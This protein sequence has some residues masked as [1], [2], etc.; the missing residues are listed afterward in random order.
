M[1]ED[2]AHRREVWARILNEPDYHII[3]AEEDGR[4][5]SSCV[6]VIVP[7]LTHELRPY[8]LIEN[9]VTHAD[10]IKGRKHASVL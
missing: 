4:I 5:V 2:S 3:V 1:P 10:R 9:V 6:C 7:N 8:T